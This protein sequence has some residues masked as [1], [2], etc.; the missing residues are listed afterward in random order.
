MMRFESVSE[1]I[2]E[3]EAL[4]TTISKIAL[5][6]SAADT[7]LSEEEILEKM[8]GILS[9]MRDSIKNGLDKDLKSASGLSGG[10]AHLARLNVSGGKN[11]SGPFMGEV[12]YNALAVSEYNACMGK[13][14]A[15]PTA[16]SAGVIPACLITLQLHREIPDSAIVMGL[17]NASAIGMVIAKNASISGAKGGCQAECGSAAAMAA[18]AMTEIMGGSPEA[19]GHAAAQ[20]LKSVLGLVCDPVAGLVEEPCIIRNAACAAVAVTSAELALAGIKSVIPVDE[21]IEA[22]E[23]VG[24]AMPECLRE[25]AKGGLAVCPTAQKIAE[26]LTASPR[27]P[28]AG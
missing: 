11:I 7:S 4:N 12:I 10:M 26:A 9:V 21:V 18:A 16:G 28:A 19:C 17:V 2:R 27:N 5:T 6:Q 1:L 23:R 15:A 25:T 8:N 20:A 14:A 13:I 22:M 24:S 3:A